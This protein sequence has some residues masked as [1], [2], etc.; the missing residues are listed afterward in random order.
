MVASIP[1]GSG[2]YPSSK[3]SDS[4]EQLADPATA[5]TRDVYRVDL[6]RPP[7]GERRPEPEGIEAT[8]PGL[9]I[10]RRPGQQTTFPL[11]DAA[12][13]AGIKGTLVPRR[14]RVRLLLSAGDAGAVPMAP[15]PRITRRRDWSYIAC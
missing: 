13:V 1:F 15:A 14:D 4:A 8:M 12:V 6:A 11:G 7:R 10:T 3:P 2:P 5:L 9:E